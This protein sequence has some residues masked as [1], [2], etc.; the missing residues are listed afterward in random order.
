M[1]RRQRLTLLRNSAPPLQP[2]Q[3]M[4]GP[5]RLCWTGAPW[6]RPQDLA[7]LRPLAQ[8]ICELGLA[9]RWRHAPGRLSFAEALG[10]PA[11]AVETVPLLPHCDYLEALGGDIGL[12]PLAPGLFNSF[13]SE[14]K[15]LEFSSAAMPWIASAS[16]PYQE[17][18]TRW[19]WAGRLCTTPRDWIGQL[20]ALL[21]PAQRQCEGRALQQLSQSRQSQQQAAQQWAQLR[22]R[23]A[24][25]PT[26]RPGPANRMCRR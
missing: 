23:R 20:Q 19:G 25:A 8:W 7:L 3:P 2:R 15:L 21:D 10:L 6:T 16:P 18:C 22:A 12:A 13:K 4:G 5:L 11:A 24:N 17:L 26:P 1:F 9:V 14:L